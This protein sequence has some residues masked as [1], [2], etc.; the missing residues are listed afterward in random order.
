MAHS[1]CPHVSVGGH[2]ARHPHGGLP[3]AITLEL[4]RRLPRSNGQR[5]GAEHVVRHGP[6]PRLLRDAVSPMTAHASNALFAYLYWP[7]TNTSAVWFAIFD[8]YGAGTWRSDFNASYTRDAMYSI[9]YHGA[10]P[11]SVA[12]KDGVAFVQGMKGGGQPETRFN[13]HGE[14]RLY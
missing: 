9:Q 8:L 6:A 2:T 3:Q 4:L 10:I 1:T 13:E 11:A 14:C 5:H 12:E 7:G